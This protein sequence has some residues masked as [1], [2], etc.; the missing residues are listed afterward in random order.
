ML[1]RA[2]VCAW[3]G[4]RAHAPASHGGPEELGLGLPCVPAAL[5]RMRSPTTGRIRRW[6][7]AM[8][9]SNAAQAA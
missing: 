6:G 4:P 8:P 3:A 7:G 9:H 2:L 5:L 1:G